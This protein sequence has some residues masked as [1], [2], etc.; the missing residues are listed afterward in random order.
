M[1]KVFVTI[2]P[3]IFYKDE[4]PEFTFCEKNTVIFLAST[5]WIAVFCTSTILLQ[6]LRVAS[7]SYLHVNLLLRNRFLH[8]RKIQRNGCSSSRNI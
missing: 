8:D 5:L 6:N 2:N 1:V 7:N 3:F 4:N